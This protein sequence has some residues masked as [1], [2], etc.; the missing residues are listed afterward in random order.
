MKEEEAHKYVKNHR[1]TEIDSNR[2]YETIKFFNNKPLDIKEVL[3]HPNV[4]RFGVK[5]TWDQ[6]H[7][8]LQE[9]G[10]HEVALDILLDVRKIRAS[11]ISKLK[12]IELIDQEL[13][14]AENLIKYLKPLPSNFDVSDLLDDEL[15]LGHIHKNI[16]QRF[17]SY[18]LEASPEKIE[19]LFRTHLHIH[20]KSLTFLCEN[21]NIALELGYSKTRLMNNGYILQTNPLNTREVLNALPT[22]AQ[23]DMRAQMKMYPK[24]IGISLQN[25][26]RTYE[27]LRKCGIADEHISKNMN[28]FSLSTKTIQNR[29]NNIKK[30]PEMRLLMKNP[31]M[32]DMIIHY[33]K[34]INRLDLLQKVKLKCTSLSVI[35]SDVFDEYVKEGKDVNRKRELMKLI[36]SMVKDDDIIEERFMKHPFFLNVPFVEIEKTYLYLRAHSFLNKQIAVAMPILLYPKEKVKEALQTIY[37]DERIKYAQVKNSQVLNTALYFLERDHHFTGNGIWRSVEPDDES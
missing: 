21:I 17:I 33:H 26:L 24:L 3:K 16:V 34:A 28:I 36:R 8:Y 32:L 14:V 6:I 31:K 7:M 27:L 19:K 23:C 25:F 4:F 22:L 35:V 12:E 9:C 20:N 30:V 1:L 2:L 37:N 11:S 5:H 29:I 15:T 10:I 13:K 18:R